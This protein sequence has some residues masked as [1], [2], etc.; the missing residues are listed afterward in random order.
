MGIR[1]LL[2]CMISCASWQSRL[3]LRT[4]KY[5]PWTPF[6]VAIIAIWSHDG[7]TRDPTHKQA[8][9]GH[10]DLRHDVQRTLEPK[11]LSHL[12]DMA[13]SDHDCLSSSDSSCVQRVTPKS[14]SCAG[15]SSA[16]HFPR[17]NLIMDDH[18]GTAI[19]GAEEGYTYLRHQ[20]APKEKCESGLRFTT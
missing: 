6:R 16:V 8:P 15:R 14:P 19:S 13:A 18:W 20:V 11:F 12:Y 5:E 1:A 17:D 9:H 3:C 7:L 2:I 4:I 10:V